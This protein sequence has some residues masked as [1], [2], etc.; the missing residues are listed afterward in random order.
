MLLIIKIRVRP[1][2]AIGREEEMRDAQ[3]GAHLFAFV[4][5]QKSPPNNNL[6]ASHERPKGCH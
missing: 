5:S 6:N 3:I 2:F 1:F 4:I